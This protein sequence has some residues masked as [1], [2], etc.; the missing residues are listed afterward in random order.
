MIGSLYSAKGVVIGQAAGF[1][2]PPDTPLPADTITV[3]D[4]ATWIGT[5][6][7]V[8][9]ASAG[10]VIFTFTGGPF[11]ANSYASPG[12]A[13][14]ALASA[15]QTAVN[16][17]LPLGYTCVVSGTAPTWTIAL[18]G[19]GAAEVITSITVGTTLTGGA[20]VVTP[21]AWTPA[22]ATD[23]GWTVNYNP[24]V[25]PINVEEQQ[26]AVGQQVTAADLSF[27]ASLAE[28]TVQSLGWAL[29][30]TSTVQAPDSTHYG[31]TTLALQPTLPQ[32]AVALE[33]QNKYGMPRRWY[34]PRMTAAAAMAQAYRRAAGNRLVPVTFTSIADQSAIE[35][36]EITSNHS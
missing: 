11:G 20:L 25:N 22:G 3:F 28:D 24:T 29:S 21:S 27:V 2:A 31:K 4:E 17:I 36:V 9:A 23:Q 6:L 14:N 19:P 34:V 8:G 1:I 26:T 10:T 5:K 12:Q 13:Y 30:A 15:I 18:V 35:M 32:V 33:T 16:A 7:T